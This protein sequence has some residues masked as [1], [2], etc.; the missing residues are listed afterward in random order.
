[1]TIGSGLGR[2]RVAWRCLWIWATLWTGARLP[3]GGGSWHY[4]A[5]GSRLLF[6][7]GQG[8]GLHL[9]AAHPELQIGPIA[10]LAATPLRLLGTAPGRLLA[11]AVMSA[12]GPLLLYALWR[13]VPLPARRPSRLLAAGLVFLPIWAELATHAGHLDDVLALMFAVAALHAVR[14]GRP[15][16]T[17]LLLAA[18]A[19]AKP[20]AAAFVSLLLALPRRDWWRGFAAWAAALA[21]A[22][23]PFV[24]YDGHTVNAARFTIP[25]AMS[26]GLR[27]FGF[28]YAHTPSWD[29]PAQLALGCLLGTLAV[30]RGRWPAVLLLGTA[31]RILLDP[32]VYSYY[33]A[34]ILL[35][36]LTYDLVLTGRRWPWLT[37]AGLLSL[38]V[39]R[40]VAH[41]APISMQVL[42]V[43]RVGYVAV[44]V[45]AAL[46]TLRRPKGRHAAGRP[47]VPADVADDGS[48]VLAA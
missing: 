34:G 46:L 14:S 25:T 5:Q 9:Y 39:A 40:L 15:V 20:W 31:A 16:V 43:L 42:G 12:T 32:E 24:L 48:G 23:A 36:A 47:A 21:A 17:G 29:R 2:D 37:S 44:A 27:V 11:I 33:T 1:M 18:S 3:G 8:Q 26:S 30:L 35:G 19:D 22:W 41:V 38:Y 45:A 13:L 7:D 6:G 28:S 4:F 10:F